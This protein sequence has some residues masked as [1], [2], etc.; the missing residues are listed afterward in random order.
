MASAYRQGLFYY[1]VVVQDISDTTT[2]KLHMYKIHDTDQFKRVPM[3][4]K[5]AMFLDFVCCLAF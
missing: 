1:Y 5:T 2:G 3:T 4:L